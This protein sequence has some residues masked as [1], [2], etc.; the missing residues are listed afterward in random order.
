MVGREEIFDVTI[1]GGGPVGLFTAFYAGMRD[2]SVKIIDSLPQLG[3]RPSVIYP[4]KFIYDIA[5]LPKIRSKDLIENLV[6]QMSRFTQT[7]VLEQT[8]ES[9]NKVED[10]VFEIKTDKGLHYSKTVLI[11]AGLGAFT[12][13]K[14]TLEHIET[15]E[16]QSVHYF[17]NDLELFRNQN[18]VVLGGGDSALDW[19]LMLEGIASNVTLVHRR[20]QFTAHEHTVNQVQSS[21]ID[22]RTPFV[23][24]AIKGESGKLSELHLKNSSTNEIEVLTVDHI[25]VNYGFLSSLGPLGQWGLE[26]DKF[27]IKVNT[28]METSIPGIYAVGDVCSYDGKVKLIATGFGEATIAINAAKH[29]IDPTTSKHVPHSSDMFL[30]RS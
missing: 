19:A 3:G 24:V 25:I 30:D 12:P 9:F 2:L 16:G 21:S 20:D 17:V 10:E 29:F 5:G 23:P 8:V 13:R 27:S 6:S 11:T 15:Y 28:K 7:I 22:V 1:I 14:L 26:M 4:E 18:V